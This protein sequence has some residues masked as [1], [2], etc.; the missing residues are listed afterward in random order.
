M[1][2]NQGFAPSLQEPPSLQRGGRQVFSGPA[3]KWDCIRRDRF[4]NVHN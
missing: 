2:L 1:A 3:G 4:Y